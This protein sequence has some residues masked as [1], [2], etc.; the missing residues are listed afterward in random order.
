[1]ALSAQ[2]T[3]MGRA[4][5]SQSIVE[6]GNIFSGAVRYHF[7]QDLAVGVE[8]QAGLIDA[9]ILSLRFGFGELR[10]GD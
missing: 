5:F 9:V 7:F 8:F 2:T 4:D 1:L 10:L 3:E 6:Q